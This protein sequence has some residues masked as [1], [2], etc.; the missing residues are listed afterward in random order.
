MSAGADHTSSNR[1][2]LE[3]LS[4]LSVLKFGSMPAGPFTSTLLGEFGAEMIKVE[5]LGKPDAIR[6]WLPIKHGHHL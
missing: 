5:K 4:G 2:Q 3:A 6:Q 1:D